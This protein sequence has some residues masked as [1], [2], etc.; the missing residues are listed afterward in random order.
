MMQWYYCIE[1]VCLRRLSDLRN[2]KFVAH[3]QG[4]SGG[5]GR[6]ACYCTALQTSV[7]HVRGLLED[8]NLFLRS[9]ITFRVAYR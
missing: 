1:R 9:T 3:L 8:R 7:K 5:P 2:C 4:G 6:I